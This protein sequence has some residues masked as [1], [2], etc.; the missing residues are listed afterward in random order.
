MKGCQSTVVFTSQEWMANLSV[1]VWTGFF[2]E[3]K[4]EKTSEMFEVETVD[5]NGRMR[6]VYAKC[7]SNPE[8]REV[9]DTQAQTY[10]IRSLPSVTQESEPSKA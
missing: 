10:H 6:R 4:I 2:K 8:G 9:S 7:I 1:R 5:S 3:W